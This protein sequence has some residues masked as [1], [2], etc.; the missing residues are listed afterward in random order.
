MKAMNKIAAS[1]MLSLGS[2]GLLFGAWQTTGAKSSTAPPRTVQYSWT[3]T[4][5]GSSEMTV[6]F[7]GKAKTVAV[8]LSGP[9]R[10]QYDVLQTISWSSTDFAVFASYAAAKAN[11]PISLDGA[12]RGALDN[13]R[14]QAAAPDYAEKITN[15][16][17]VGL[18]GRRIQCSFTNGTKKFFLSGVIFTD[19]TRMWQVI[20]TGNTSLA[21]TNLTNRILASIKKSATEPGG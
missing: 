13:V 12:A 20:C 4:P 3:R 1:L 17:I 16:T 15:A 7:P 11:K 6:E 18:P 10:A 19:R 5:I 9:V 14:G 21:N 2:F 8:P